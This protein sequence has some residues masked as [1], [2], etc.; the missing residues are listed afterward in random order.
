MSSVTHADAEA[1]NTDFLLDLA[2]QV[3]VEAVKHGYVIAPGVYRFAIHINN[4]KMASRTLTFYKNSDQDVV[5]CIDQEFIESYQIILNSTE[6]KIMDSNGCYNL[7]AIENSSL[8]VDVGKQILSLSLP[9][10][11]LLKVPRGYVSPKLF[12]EGI[13][14]AIVNYMANTSYTK[15]SNGQTYQNSSVLLNG[16]FNLG[17]WR[18]R[19]QSMF[20]QYAGEKQQWQTISNKLE[21]NI[22]SHQA[23]LELGDAFTNSDVFDSYNFRGIQVSSDI[24]QLPI[25]LQN[26]A[27]VI[28][29][30]A[31]T[32]AVVDVRQN[33][34][35]IYSTHVAPG[36]FVIDDL[37]AANESGDLEI[38]VN[39]SDGRVE[40]FTQAFSSVPN[41]VRPG[42]AK[43]QLTAG[44]YRSGDNDHYHP[45]FGQITYAYGLNNYISPYTGVLVAE[46]Y[47]SLVTGLAWSLGSFGSLSFDAT[48]AKN[49]LQNN[50]KKD[51]VS[52]RFLYAKSL[53]Q[54][55]TNFRLVGYRY[56]TSGYYSFSDAV[57]EKLKWKNGVYEYTSDSE[58]NL[59]N[60]GLYSQEYSQSYSSST[61]NN[62]KN[63]SQISVN[64]DLGRFGQLYVNLNK[65]DY[66]Q[67]SYNSQSW[68]VGY[69]NNYKKM[70]YSVY[71]QQDKSLFNPSTY[72][73][74][75]SLNFLLDQPKL[76]RGRNAVSNTTYQFTENGGGAIQTS[77]SASFLKDKNLNLQMQ[78]A[79]ANNGNQSIAISSTYRGSKLNSN[80][81]Y[82]YDNTSQQIMAGMS[83]G[84][85]LHSGGILLG[86][87]MNSNPILVEAKGAQGV[88]L[89][90]QQ[91]LKIDR[92]GYAIISSSSAY[93]KNRIALKA[94]DLGQNITVDN[95]VLNDIV[96]T[97][98]AIVK[99]KFD[100]RN[101]HS[102]LVNLSY[103]DRA[104]MTGAT[105]L[106]AE[107]KSIM[108]MVG[109]NGQAYLNAVESNQKLLAKWGE[110][111]F[112]Q[113]YFTLP[114]LEQRDFGYDEITLQCHAMGNK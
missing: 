43:Y 81:N 79:N 51:G 58:Q 17:A 60:N 37:Y 48:Y 29:G 80:L 114:E 52:L 9:Q 47:Y 38:T 84:I 1:F 21:R 36:Q 34:Y 28:R 16:G 96:P 73:I 20:T 82:S 91:G 44:Q 41:M 55:G 25:G 49:K 24:A 74:G 108:G 10:V 46:D 76:L 4:E 61:F 13:N 105:V 26:Y 2:D 54:L 33:G 107:S 83:G 56:S 6:Q 75:M 27:P 98:F 109:L 72:S 66:W 90:N 67:K 19:N 89:E 101:G 57:Q 14:A 30:M 64:Q 99:V 7:K 112:Q 78:L 45:Y 31:F 42:Q 103:H 94:E 69:N 71:Y 77:L 92:S 15:K 88:R 63:Q 62:K 111:E 12:N 70:N 23:R 93:L 65:V 85:L 97:K 8:N 86:Q 40:R 110:D 113:C 3:S 35:L 18:Y 11:N 95:A 39:E 87:Q 53:N 102:I 50:E 68:Q 100:V 59:Y 32:N 104:V 106:D 5:P 22:I